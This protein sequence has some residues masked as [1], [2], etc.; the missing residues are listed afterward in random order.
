M[1]ISLGH[2]NWLNLDFAN[3]AKSTFDIDFSIKSPIQNLSFQQA[4][5]YT[6]NLIKE[7]YKDLHLCLSGGLDSEFVAKV[8]LRN[9]I[10]FKPVILMTPLNTAEV[11]YAF[12]LCNTY[13]LD[14]IVLDYRNLFVY[15]K[16]LKQIYN[17]SIKINSAPNVSLI[18]NVIAKIIKGADILLGSGE[19]CKICKDYNEP[20]GEIF[21]FEKHDFHLDLEF[22]NRHPGSFFT[23][24]PE[25]F[26][27]FVKEIDITKNS[28]EAKA[29][30]YG[31]L[32]RSKSDSIIYQAGCSAELKRMIISRVEKMSFTEIA[33]L[34]S[35]E[36]ILKIFLKRC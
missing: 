32:T 14:P 22:P 9:N 17:T 10:S 30:L 18:P 15:D 31:V 36:E 28:Q 25:I 26:L 24:T 5:D 23:Y 16:L 6:A 33:V 2:D 35:R 27:T 11:W 8:L 4:A 7:K 20:L 1:K 34:L 13:K 21:E 3:V 29:E 19:S 12:K